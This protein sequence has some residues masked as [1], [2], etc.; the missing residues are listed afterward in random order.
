MPAPVH[1]TFIRSP[2]PAPTLKRGDRWSLQPVVTLALEIARRHP[3]VLLSVYTGAAGEPPT[4]ITE[5]PRVGI[6]AAIAS[7]RQRGHLRFAWAWAVSAAGTTDYE[8]IP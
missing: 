8:E 5:A 7:V 1:T 3:D 2:N 4:I 6:I